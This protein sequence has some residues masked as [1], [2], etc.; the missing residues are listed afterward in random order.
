MFVVKISEQH[1]INF[2]PRIRPSCILPYVAFYFIFKISSM[3]EIC[4]PLN[5]RNFKI[6]TQTS[7]HVNITVQ[8]NITNLDFICHRFENQIEK[9]ILVKGNQEPCWTLCCVSVLWFVQIDCEFR[10][11]SLKCWHLKPHS[12]FWGHDTVWV[13]GRGDRHKIYKMRRINRR[14]D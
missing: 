3:T 13:G 4:V 8:N 1:F 9:N 10:I 6:S 7:T 12:T 14:L 2:D 11:S 5:R